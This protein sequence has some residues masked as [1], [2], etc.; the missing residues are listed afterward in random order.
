MAD[1]LSALL[2]DEAWRKQ[3]GQA[4]YDRHQSLFSGPH[5]GQRLRTILL[6]CPHK[7]RRGLDAL[8]RAKR[9]TA[10]NGRPDA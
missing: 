7:H 5:Y 4:A 1:L 6:D 8:W 10:C 3:V 2:L 9:S